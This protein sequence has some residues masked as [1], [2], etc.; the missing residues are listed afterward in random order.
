M[1]ANDASSFTKVGY[2]IML[3]LI[4][5]QTWLKNPHT[6]RVLQRSYL[7]VQAQVQAYA[8]IS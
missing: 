5:S 4:L 3:K 6:A 1:E 7:S 2:S 8:R